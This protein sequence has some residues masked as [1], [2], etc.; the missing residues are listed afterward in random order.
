MK[1][2]VLILLYGLF[3]CLLLEFGLGYG[4]Y[5]IV[6]GQSFSYGRVKDERRQIIEENQIAG[7]VAVN[8]DEPKTHEG[9]KRRRFSTEILHPYLG[10]VVDFHDKEC[11]AFGFCDDR[12]RSYVTRL[13]GRDFPEALSGHYRYHGRFCCPW[14][15]KHFHPGE[16]GT[17]SVHHPV[18]KG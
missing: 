5:W 10:Y 1:K 13:N 12:M 4:G 9:A 3:L 11:P 17:G 15:S 14:D 8:L 7:R 18:I 2:I 6:P 16:D